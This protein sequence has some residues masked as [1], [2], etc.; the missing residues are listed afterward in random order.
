[1]KNTLKVENGKGGVH[2]GAFLGT[3]SPGPHIHTHI[4]RLL[5]PLHRWG[6]GRAESE[7]S[8]ADPRNPQ[9]A[10][11][12]NPGPQV[13]QNMGCVQTCLGFG[14]EWGDPVPKL[15]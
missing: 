9:D 15:W 7:S 14:K 12:P 1:M 10:C 13:P 6:L 8:G 2:L 4:L 3:P 5:C 11:L